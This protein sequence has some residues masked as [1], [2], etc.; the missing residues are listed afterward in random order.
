MEKAIKWN[1][2][3]GNIIVSY[4]G[5]GDGSISLFSDVANKGLDR[6]QELNITT[7]KGDVSIKL[8]VIQYGLY[9]TYDTTNDRFILADGGSFNV[10]KEGYHESFNN[11]YILC[12]GGTLNV[13]INEL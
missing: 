12:N 13:L 6:E 8:K 9:E 2:G 3:D 4:D 1:E 7:D 5:N 11:D 10:F